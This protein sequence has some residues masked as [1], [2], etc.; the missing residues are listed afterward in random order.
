MRIFLKKIRRLIDDDS[1]P[2]EEVHKYWENPQDGT[3]QP[4]NYVIGVSKSEY[5]FDKIKQFN[6]EFKI[7]E[8]GCN[9]GRNLDYLYQQGYTSRFFL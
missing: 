2:I 3:N 4:K 5:L 9:V 7:L 1:K 8:I 6:K